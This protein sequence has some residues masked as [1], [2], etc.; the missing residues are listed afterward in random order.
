MAAVSAKQGDPRMGKHDRRTPPDW[1][2][3][4]RIVLEAI[5]A[6]AMIVI[7]LVWEVLRSHG[8]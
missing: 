5:K 1:Y 7:R 4:I 8:S 2:W 3:R 6:G